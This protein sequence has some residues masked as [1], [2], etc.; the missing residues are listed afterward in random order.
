MDHPTKF[1]RPRLPKVPSDLGNAGNET[2]Q[3]AVNL[4]LKDAAIMGASETLTANLSG[5]HA[6]EM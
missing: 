2:H 3:Q 5:Q 1:T 6:A 4:V